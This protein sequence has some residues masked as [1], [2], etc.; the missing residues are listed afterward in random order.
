MRRARRGSGRAAAPSSPARQSPSR[1]PPRRQTR[2]R[3]RSR[4][5]GAPSSPAPR[6]CGSTPLQTRWTGAGRPWCERR[7]RSP[8]ASYRDRRAPLA[9]S[10]QGRRLRPGGDGV[11]SGPHASQGR[12]GPSPRRHQDVQ[13]RRHD[14]LLVADRVQGVVRDRGR[15]P[16]GRPG[17]DRVAHVGEAPA[18]RS[19]LVSR[20]QAG[21]SLVGAARDP[22][23]DSPSSSTASSSSASRRRMPASPST[24]SPA[25]SST[26]SSSRRCS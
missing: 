10:S 16:R 25:P 17:A 1:G 2:A 8:H 19:A 15:R 20:C 23:H 4:R 26:A 21:A 14:R 3:G 6:S 22:L 9:H 12:D 5:S 13:R 11:C 24:R 7:Q 18:R